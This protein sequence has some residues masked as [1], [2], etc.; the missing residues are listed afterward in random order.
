LDD[1]LAIATNHNPALKA[2]FYNWK[3]ELEKA[4]YAGALPDPMFTY[5]Y[6]V[7]NVETRV[8]PQ[9]HRFGLMQS[10]PWFG[11]LGAKKAIATEAANAA[12][13]KYNAEKLRLYYQVKAAYYDY[14]YLGRDLSLTRDNM[15]LLKFWESVAR[16]RYKVALKQHPDVIKAQVE[17]G[18]LEDRLLSL[19]EQ[20]R[21]T[22]ARFHAALNT[23]NSLEIPIPTEI[24]LEEAQ[25]N[26]DSVI[27]LAISNNPDIS[28]IQHLMD[29][30]QA[31]IRLADR[32]SLPNFTLGVNYIETGE[33]SNPQM[34]ESGKDPWMVNIGINLP[35][36]FGKN[37]SRKEEAKSRYNSARQNLVDIRNRIVVHIERVLFE[38]EDA[39]R[40]ARLYRDGLIP[41]AE[42]SLNAN[43]AAYQAG[44]TDFLNVL[45]SQRQ[46][47]NFQLIYEKARRNMAKKKAELEM[48]TGSSL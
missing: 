27:E 39:L 18:K 9:N 48:I 4:G 44:E 25:L 23:G 26:R 15:E 35:I 5:S 14:F 10:F 42:Q 29:K 17:L 11:T 28:A 6:F 16:T 38:Y 47:L 31:G 43:Y 3:A 33:A 2:A 40:K 45:D 34:D 37:S 8:G 21:P 46:L 24:Y 13:Q 36:W 22:K 41:K 20:I 7:E 19:E 30:E 32:S 12:Y 1:Y